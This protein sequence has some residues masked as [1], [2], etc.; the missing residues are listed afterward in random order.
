M[1]SLEAENAMHMGRDEL[2]HMPRMVGAQGIAALHLSLGTW[3]FSEKAAQCWLL[4]HLLP[5]QFLQ[6][7]SDKM[8]P[9]PK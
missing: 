5:G 7:S 8:G 4:L 2:L 1:H 3:D 6:V 9:A